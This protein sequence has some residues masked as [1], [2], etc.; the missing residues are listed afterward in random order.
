MEH[1]D[2]LQTIKRFM[3]LSRM[4]S[5]RGIVTFSNFLNTNELNLFYQEAESLETGYRL[6]GGYAFAERQMIAFIPDALYYEWE[7]PIARLRFCPSHAKFAEELSHRDVLGALMHLGVDRSR[8]GD[9]KPD[10][11]G[12]VVFCEETV[13]EFLLESLVQI[14]HTAVSGERVTDENFNLEQTFEDMDGIVPSS[15]LDAIVAFLTK[16]SRS[17]SVLL[18]Q[19]KKV[20]VNSR[21]VTS[22][23]YECKEGDVISIRGFGKFVYEGSGGETK[24]GRL[25][26]N[27]KKY[28]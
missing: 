22:N 28:V 26:I 15:R 18:I 5:R 11:T 12:Y 4:A 27:L 21:S 17:K 16:H 25:K 13:S 1:K 3:D 6:S 20:F 14:R 2:E 24:K 8:I 23:A 7:F 9:I 10:G 19:A